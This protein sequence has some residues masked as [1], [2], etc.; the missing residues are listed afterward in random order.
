MLL[1]IS[2]DV[3]SSSPCKMLFAGKEKDPREKLYERAFK[4]SDKRIREC[5]SILFRQ[6]LMSEK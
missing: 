2:S 4:L 5:K 6:Q 3:P 1:D